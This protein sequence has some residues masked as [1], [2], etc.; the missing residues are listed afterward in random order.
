MRSI[1]S[2]ILTSVTLSL[3]ILASVTSGIL[4]YYQNR[5]VQINTRSLVVEQISLV[6]KKLDVYSL[7]NQID[8]ITNTLF[9]LDYIDAVAL[10]DKDCRLLRRQPI[11]EDLGNPC[12]LNSANRYELIIYTNDNVYQDSSGAP[13][14]ILA[15]VPKR[16]LLLS[17]QETIFLLIMLFMFILITIFFLILLINRSVIIPIEMVS[18]FITKVDKDALNKQPEVPY[19]LLPIFRS[20]S[21]R[22]IIIE[23]A[24]EQLLEKKKAEMI[25]LVSRQVAHDIK[26]PISALKAGLD[27]IHLKPQKANEL[28]WSAY[29]R[30]V[31]II[32]DL[33]EV[34]LVSFNMVDVRNIILQIISEKYFISN[35]YNLKITTN[36]GEIKS[37][38]FLNIHEGNFLRV[39]S[40]LINNSIESMPNNCRVHIEL[41]SDE[42]VVRIRV[43]DNGPGIDAF[44]T[45]KLFLRGVSMGKVN[46]KGLGLSYAKEVV[47]S[48]GGTI[49]LDSNSDCGAHFIISIPR[50]NK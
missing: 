10:F 8:H 42:S 44:M 3:G 37:P 12:E 49:T 13:Y 48:F 19:E 15:R 23:K 21:E 6:V 29:S 47:E 7:T 5:K 9:N 39:L 1:R 38:V 14:Y 26:S 50:I 41:I 46:G 36:V 34:R 40:N 35:E 30:V 32:K 27:N 22:D 43:S 16:L 33:E 45:K 2:S 17:L 20:V 31:D 4:T 24:N 25:A 18:N 28:I 11:N